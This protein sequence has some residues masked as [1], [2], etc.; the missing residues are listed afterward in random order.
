MS[1]I[2]PQSVRG[3]REESGYYVLSPC[4]FD[5]NLHSAGVVAQLKLANSRSHDIP[6][7]EF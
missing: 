6:F 7:L 3:L 1:S 5:A 4:E 2:V